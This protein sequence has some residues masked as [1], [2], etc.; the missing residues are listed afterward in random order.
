MER[1][2]I[3]SDRRKFAAGTVVRL[4]VDNQHKLNILD[5]GLVRLLIEHLDQLASDQAVRAIVLTGEG[6]RAFIGGADLREMA[7]FEPDSARRFIT[8]LH[9]LCLRLR[10][11]PVP[12]IARING[13]CLG[14][15]MEIAASCDLRVASANAEFGMP[16]VRV[17]I[18]SVIEAA[19]LPRII[20][21][22]R[23][24]DLVLTGD[25]ISANDA[26]A[27]GFVRRPVALGD[28]DTAVEQCL[29]SVLTAG[30]S[31]IR[32]QKALL[33]HWDTDSLEGAINAS[34]DIFASAYRTS[35]P[36]RMMRSFLSG[37]PAGKSED[38]EP[39]VPTSC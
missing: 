26:Y 5:S 10:E 9:E 16:E 23:A 29:E 24:R 20:G 15:G 17:G 25:I 36:E 13:Y 34:I 6:E 27:M 11:H 3:R 30:P 19:L 35:E 4:S 12:T 38:A 31:A 18:P 7:G 22:G 2:T 8:A 14:G 32:D 1:P 39:N 33:K 28:L 21:A 37:K